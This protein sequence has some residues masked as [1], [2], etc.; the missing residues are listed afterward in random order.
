MTG[1]VRVG[2]GHPSCMIM[3]IQGTREVCG[4]R[5]LVVINSQ[6]GSP[7][8]YIEQLETKENFWS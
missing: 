4:L 5:A 1:L 6:G 2:K 8:H 3:Q 7:G